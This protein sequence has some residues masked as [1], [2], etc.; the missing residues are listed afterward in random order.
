ME[1]IANVLLTGG[2]GRLGKKLIQAIN[3]LDFSL[4]VL[5]RVS[6]PAP[7]TGVGYVTADLTDR[8][9]LTG[10]LNRNYDVVVH[11]ASNPRESE[12]V[13]VNGT[14][15]LLRALG[16]RNVKNFI[17]LSIV[18]VDKTDYRYYQ[19]KMKAEES[20]AA[21][22]I[23]YSILRVTQ[24]HDFVRERI[25]A[26]GGDSEISW[27]PAGLKFQSIDLGDVVKKILLLVK[28]QP[29]YSISQI[30]GPEVLSVEDMIRDYQTIVSRDKNF[31]M[32]TSLNDF[33]KL[34]ASGINL[35]PNNRW[36]SCAWRDYLS[37]RQN[38]SGALDERKNS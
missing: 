6:V 9:S 1:K 15:N 14:Q 23:P 2:T 3:T 37:L 11:C 28:G 20:I 31:E 36:G 24:F 17:Y 27:I 33:Q 4:D 16:G 7:N 22:G 35:C 8:T 29:T 10:A 32:T 12:S 5:T 34:F 18:G 38:E 30:G 19:S 26:D 21:S 25:L 13:D